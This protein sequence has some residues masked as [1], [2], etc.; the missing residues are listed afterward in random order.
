VFALNLPNVLTL[1]RILLVPVLVVALLD[2]TANGDLLAAIVF[3]LASFTDAMDGY[4]A[5]T[6]NAITSFGKLMDPIADKLLI[7]AALVALVSLHR[8]PAWVA[9]VII[10]RELTVTVTRMQATQHGVVIAANAWGKAKTIVQVAAIF[11]LIAVGEPSPA[12]VDGLVYAAVAIT[13]V[14][15]IDY[16]FG[17]R[18]VLRDAEARRELAAAAAPAKPGGS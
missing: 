15:G 13:I 10:A 8:L 16:F 5:R 11:F 2:E 12:W 1:I 7:I 6:R 3:A 18:R 9:M 4:L 14:S 17:L